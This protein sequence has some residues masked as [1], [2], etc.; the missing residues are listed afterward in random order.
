MWDRL[1]SEIMFYGVLGRNSTGPSRGG[2]EKYQ[3]VRNTRASCMCNFEDC[4][5]DQYPNAKKPHTVLLARHADIKRNLKG[6][7][8]VE[9]I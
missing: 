1:I 6:R 3:K 7:V 4:L 9:N 8:P 2:C 5:A